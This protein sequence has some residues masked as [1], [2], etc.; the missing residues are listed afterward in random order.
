MAT[1]K[2]Q[3]I[4]GKKKQ[5]PEIDITIE[6]DEDT[7]ILDAVEDAHPD[8]EF[9]FSCRAGSCSS[10]AARVVEGELDQE[11]QNFLDDEQVEKGWSLLCVAKPMSD[12]VIKTHQEAYLV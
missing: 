9:P 3:L 2:V 10:C 4:K 8:L 6:V 11:D 1:Y 7:Y 5:P 12:C